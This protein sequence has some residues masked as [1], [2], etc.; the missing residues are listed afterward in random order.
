MV[1][2]D[3]TR[4]AVDRHRAEP[5]SEPEPAPEHDVEATKQHAVWSRTTRQKDETV[6]DQ[7][8]APPS[9]SVDDRTGSAPWAD[10]LSFDLKAALDAVVMVHAEIPEEAFTASILGTERI[11]S[12]CIKCGGRWPSKCIDEIDQ[13]SEPT[14][15]KR[16][17]R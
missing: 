10:E 8:I 17:K 14:D 2:P 16:K 1:G 12:G 9:T 13:L 4:T 7:V 15:G 11:G 3:A 5:E 6:G